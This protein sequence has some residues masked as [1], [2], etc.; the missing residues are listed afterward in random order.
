MHV[1]TMFSFVRINI[2]VECT[3]F[4]VNFSQCQSLSVNSSETEYSPRGVIC[5]GT[6]IC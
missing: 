3:G 2:D 5:A 1:I 6:Y 4:E